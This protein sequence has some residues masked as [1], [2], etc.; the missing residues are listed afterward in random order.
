VAKIVVK[1]MNTGRVLL[2]II[3]GFDVDES[4]DQE[5]REK[6]MD[7]NNSKTK[8]KKKQEVGKTEGSP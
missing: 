1:I 2:C 4:D 6:Y 5:K 3:T 8:K 7:K